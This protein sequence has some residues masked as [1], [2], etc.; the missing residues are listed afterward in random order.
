MNWQFSQRAKRFQPN[1]FNV[2]KDLKGQ[3]L[4]SGEWVCDLSV[5]TPD[6]PVAEHI[7][8]AAAQ[9]A[10]DAENYKY[11][12]G[13]LPELTSAVQGWYAR[14]YGVALAPEEI[15]GVYGSQE[16]IAHIAL[17]LCD[18]GDVVLVPN[19]CYPIFEA[20]PY[21]NGAEIAY[22]PLDEKNGYLPD[23]AA[24]DES[25]ARR[26]KMMIVSF[27]ANPVGAMAPRAFYDDLVAFARKYG[28]CV[29]HDNA[30]SEIVFDGAKGISFLSV[31]GA[32]DVGVEFNSLSKTYNLTGARLSFLLGNR[33]ILERFRALRTQIDYGL[34]LVAQH[35]AIAAL[36]GPQ[37]GVARQRAEYQRR[38][39]ALC[40][41]LTAAG[42]NVPDGKGTMF[43]WAK[44]PRGWEDDEAFVT[45]LFKRTGVLCTPGSA[46]ASLGQGHVRFALVRPVEDLTACVERI[47]G[48]GML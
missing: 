16:G 30:Y 13:D 28:I 14:R 15:M 29:V 19:P 2:L 48:S 25:I 39:D 6:F 10:L 1:I 43:V 32:M 7:R 46:F 5:G 24:I 23:L 42:W 37:E 18:P 8:A 21:L 17:T 11:A 3:R 12:L 9:A 36:N 33:A 41:G 40:H 35:A 31:P 27:P 22:Y 45:E 44:T 20:G 34:F 47:A 4:S 38:R 26:A